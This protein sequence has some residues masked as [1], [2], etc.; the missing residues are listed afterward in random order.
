MLYYPQL[1]TGAV[2][3]FPMTR[4]TPVPSISNLLPSGDTIRMSDP[5]AAVVRW[6]LRYSN[7]ADEEWA[8]LD[9]LFEAAQGRLATFTFLDPM[10]NLLMWSEDWTRPVWSSDPLLQVSAGV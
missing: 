6:R 10:D 7:L 3:Q 2:S 9:Q 5:G 8:P 1:S 4:R